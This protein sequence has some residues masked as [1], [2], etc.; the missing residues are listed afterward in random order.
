MN[1]K[2]LQEKYAFFRL[3]LIAQSSFVAFL[4]MGFSVCS[5][6]SFTWDTR[7]DYAFGYIAPLFI[8][9]I[10]FDRKEKIFA[11][12]S[13]QN[14]D[15][16][17]KEQKSGVLDYLF[18]FFFGSMAICGA[19]VYIFFM[20][21]YSA[22]QNWHAVAFPVTFG[23]GF[24]AFALA[25]F[26]SFRTVEGSKKSLRE[27][28]G[29]TFLFVFP[30]FSLLVSAPLFSIVEERISLFLLSK[31]A[32]I[33]T[34]VMD[35]L[36]YAVELKGN[37]ISFPDGS[38]GVE[39]AC[40]GIRSL[41]ACLFAG[42]FLAAVFL[43]NFIKKLLLVLSSMILAFFNNILRAL[44]LS[45]YAYE[46]G[47]DSI[48]GAVHDIAGYFVLGMTVLGLFML[49]PIFQLDPRPKDFR[50]GNVENNNQNKKDDEPNQK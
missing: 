49:L 4:L 26:S 15:C 25:Y 33:S 34:A 5:I 40:S 30:C 44:F 17:I 32:Y 29:F 1:F 43:N 18:N 23:F 39:D 10:I 41:T 16:G 14:E 31:V 3:P 11:Y 50:T 12:F 2:E 36:G 28:L 46:N 24:L 47:S 9:Y 48:S 27:R 22:L 13:P 8:L 20:A 35:A 7:D 19:A 38:V 21:I 45:I 42:T 6:L 37:V